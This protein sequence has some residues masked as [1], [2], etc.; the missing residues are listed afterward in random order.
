MGLVIEAQ[1]SEA[2]SDDFQVGMSGVT[3]GK[4]REGGEGRTAPSDTIQG[5]TPW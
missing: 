3:R 5:V 4:G 1:K 2:T